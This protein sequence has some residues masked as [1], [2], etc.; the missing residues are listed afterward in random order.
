MELLTS[1]FTL[2]REPRLARNPYS[3]LWSPQE[4]VLN[5]H[6]PHQLLPLLAGAFP[7]RLDMKRIRNDESVLLIET[8]TR[9]CRFNKSLQI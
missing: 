3:L 4:R 8:Y 6:L 1:I 2:P 9:L 7:F 5:R